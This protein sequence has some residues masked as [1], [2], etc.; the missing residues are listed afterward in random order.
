MGG[1][2]AE[3]GLVLEAVLDVGFEL[4]V[5]EAGEVEGY[6]GDHVVQEVRMK[7]Q[8]RK[9]KTRKTMA[10]KKWVALKNS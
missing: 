2:E 1:F 7:L 5:E 4:G 3:G 8:C 6:C 10:K 9:K